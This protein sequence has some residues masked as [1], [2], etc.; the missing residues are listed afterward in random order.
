MN[1]HRIVVVAM[2]GVLPFDLSM[3]SEVFGRIRNGTWQPYRVR[4]CGEAKEVKAG[5]F[6]LKVQWDLSQ[7]SDADTVFIPGVANTM[8]PVS[9]DVIEAIRGAAKRGA[10]IASVCTG[11]FVLAATGL[12]DGKRATT[13]WLAADDL[14]RLYPQID[15]DPHVLY[16]DNGQ[17]LTSAGAVAGM[18]LCLHLIRKDYGSALAAMA[19]R[20]AVAPLEREGGQAQFILQEPPTSASSLTHLLEWM[21]CNLDNDLSLHQIA[22][23][24]AMSPRTLSRKFVAQVG[25]TPLQWVLKARIRKSQTLLEST[26]LSVEQIASLVG[27]DSAT[28]FRERFMKIVGTSPSGYRKTFGGGSIARRSLMGSSPLDSKIA[29]MVGF[30]ADCLPA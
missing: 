6:D 5:D 27:F 26:A 9:T 19:A 29:D 18:D 14:A 30:P 13:H 4:V 20:F 22:L 25:I 28:S 3:P 1:P 17:I 21:S 16:V 8:A 23:K 11:A 24:A 10:R 12:L 2:H 15:V 7:I